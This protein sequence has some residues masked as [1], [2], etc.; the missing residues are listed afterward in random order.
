MV[1]TWRFYS[2]RTSIFVLENPFQLIIYWVH[3]L[4]PSGS[5]RARYCLPSRFYI[6]FQEWSGGCNGFSGAG[7]IRRHRRLHRSFADF[8]NPQSKP[9]ITAHP[10]RSGVAMFIAWR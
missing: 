4:L 9:A 8:M 7:R 6:R 2:S 3:S 1:S 10:E 5:S